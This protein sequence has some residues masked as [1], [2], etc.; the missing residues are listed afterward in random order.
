MRTEIECA[1]QLPASSA[2]LAGRRVALANAVSRSVDEWRRVL[3][4]HGAVLASAPDAQTDL[5]LSAHAVSALCSSDAKL[6]FDAP[7]VRTLQQLRSL[8]LSFSR[9]TH[10]S[11]VLV[12]S[13]LVVCAKISPVAG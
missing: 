8:C 7:L 4:A 3:A 5:I 12:K 6:V 10:V 9:F 13:R 2:A 11:L 1:P